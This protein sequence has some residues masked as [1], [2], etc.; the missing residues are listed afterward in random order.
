MDALQGLFGVM[1]MLTPSLIFLTLA[2]LVEL[3]SETPNPGTKG[4]RS[5]EAV[6]PYG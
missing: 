5:S 4:L 2:L 1:A 3:R 6:V